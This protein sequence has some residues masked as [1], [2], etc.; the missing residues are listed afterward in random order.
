MIKLYT[1]IMEYR[2]GT[3]IS[4]V[5]AI[6]EKDALMKGVSNLDPKAIEFLGEKIKQKM[7]EEA[8]SEIP[9]AINGVVNVFLA[10]LRPYGNFTLIHIIATDSGV[11][12]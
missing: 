12:R 6:D 10:S 3:Y 11:N 4:Q 8:H 5:N 1:L 7:I 9:V 2:G